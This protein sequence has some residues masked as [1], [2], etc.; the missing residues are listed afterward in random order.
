MS[1]SCCLRSPGLRG[2]GRGPGRSPAP[3]GRAASPAAAAAASDRRRRRGGPHGGRRGRR[4]G[5]PLPARGAAA[6]AR[7]G[8][9]P[10]QRRARNEQAPAPGSRTEGP[11]LGFFPRRRAAGARSPRRGAAGSAAAS[12]GEQ[13]PGLTSA[14]AAAA[15]SG[16]RS[17]AGAAAAPPLPP[18]TPGLL[19]GRP[20]RKFRSPPD[21]CASNSGGGGC[22]GA[23][24]WGRECPSCRPSRGQRRSSPRS[25]EPGGGVGR[26]GRARPPPCDFA[27]RRCFAFP[28]RRET[29]L[30]VGRL[31]RSPLFFHHRGEE[32]LKSKHQGWLSEPSATPRIWSGSRLGRQTT[33]EHLTGV[34]E[35][36]TPPCILSAALLASSAVRNEEET[37]DNPRRY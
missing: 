19:S 8:P 25:R 24:F 33:L 18:H 6:P 36:K 10:P 15:A 12:S 3:R 13:A 31:P 30:P 26:R 37:C 17:R 16:R 21:P 2:R 23:G 7:P 34:P 22:E 20:R 27:R 32:I 1:A 14:A 35:W 9:P 29:S 4:R 28:A 11:R 5:R